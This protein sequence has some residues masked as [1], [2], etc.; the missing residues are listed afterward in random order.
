MK[1]HTFA[2]KKFTLIELLVVIAIIAILA[3]I[4]MPALSQARERGRGTACI[5][6]LKQL[7]MVTGGYWDAYEAPV[8]NQTPAGWTWKRYIRNQYSAGEFVNGGI[9]HCPSAKLVP[10]DGD[11]IE[12]NYLYNQCLSSG[13][14]TAR[15][16]AK[17]HG[18]NIASRQF[19][20]ADSIDPIGG[21]TPNK[22]QYNKDVP[23]PNSWS[24][25][26]PDQPCDVAYRHAGK[27]NVAFADSHVETR[28]GIYR[29]VGNDHSNE[30][31]V[32]YAYY[33]Q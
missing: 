6:N 24:A 1:N 2:M 16:K 32:R 23:S 25:S 33:G 27:A 11:N 22:F 20:Y 7:M 8:A 31:I 21:T 5:S 13:W 28:E 9:V 30:E 12:T 18:G 17:I 29:G 10:R 4:L 3:A 19:V 15:F 14:G 26:S